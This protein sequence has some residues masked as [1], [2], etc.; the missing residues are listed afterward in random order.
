MSMDER[1]TEVN[2]HSVNEFFKTLKTKDIHFC[3][4]TCPVQPKLWGCNWRPVCYQKEC[5]HLK[6]WSKKNK[7]EMRK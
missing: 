5:V 4:E 1:Y 6:Q 2:V 3:K 7:R